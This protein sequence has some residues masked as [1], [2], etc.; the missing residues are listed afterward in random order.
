MQCIVLALR[1]HIDAADHAIAF[2]QGKDIVAVFA[3]GLGH[4]D[5][6]A[7]V[8]VEQTPQTLAVPDQGIERAEHAQAI[9]RRGLVG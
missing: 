7:V 2:Q 6:D 3:L 4:E 9:G 1:L 8:K 5:F